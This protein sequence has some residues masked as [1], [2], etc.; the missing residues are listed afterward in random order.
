MGAALY[1]GYDYVLFILKC[2]YFHFY[3][4]HNMPHVDYNHYIHVSR[5]SFVMEN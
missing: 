3:K 5:N 4:E 1:G 2:I